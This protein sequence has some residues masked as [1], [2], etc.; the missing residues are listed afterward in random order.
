MSLIKSHC[1]LTSLHWALSSK[2]NKQTKKH[3]EI[4]APTKG[5]LWTEEDIYVIEEKNALNVFNLFVSADCEKDRSLQK[6]VSQL[7]ELAEL[8]CLHQSVPDSHPLT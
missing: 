6:A 2:A 4:I 3:I 8:K 5:Q 7:L 1:L